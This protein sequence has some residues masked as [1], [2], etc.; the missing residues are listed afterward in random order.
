MWTWAVSSIHECPIYRLP[1]PF[2]PGNKL[3]FW[4]TLSGFVLPVEVVGL[5]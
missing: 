4:D 5:I 1:R 2:L 3:S